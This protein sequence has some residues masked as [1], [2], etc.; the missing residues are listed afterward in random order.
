LTDAERRVVQAYSDFQVRYRELLYDPASIEITESHVLGE[1]R[2][3]SVEVD[4]LG[5]SGASFDGEPGTVWTVVHRQE[6]RIVINLINL[7]DQDDSNWNTA[8]KDSTTAAVVRIRSTH[9]CLGSNS[10]GFGVVECH[11]G[12]TY[13]VP[14]TDFGFCI[15]NR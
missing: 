4:G 14:G 12:G 13:V 3:F 7:M 11:L 9:V 1:N 15:Q 2:E 8:K 6:Q 10:R 5:A